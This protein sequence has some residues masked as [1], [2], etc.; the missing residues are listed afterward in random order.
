MDKPH[1]STG[2]AP[3]FGERFAAPRTGLL[4]V[5]AVVLLGW[6]LQALGSIAVP[7]VF[8]FFLTLL[9]APVDRWVSERVPGKVKWLGHVA[10]M[11]TVVLGVAVFAACLWLAAQQLV[12][13]FAGEPGGLGSLLPEVSI[14][15]G[16]AG[17]ETGTGGE[18]GGAGPAG[19]ASLAGIGDGG[20]AE[21]D[22][23]GASLLGG[24]ALETD[25]A[26][27][28]AM[29]DG[30]TET[31]AAAE[32]QGSG[33][34]QVVGMARDAAG[35]LASALS[36]WAAN[37]AG[38]I[39]AAAGSFVSA[40]VLVFFL[41]LLMLV[42]A[43]RWQGKLATLL[44]KGA[45]ED[46][47]DATAV[48][49]DR[50]RRFLLI[51]L[52]IGLITAALYVGWLWVFGI[53]LLLVWGLLAVLLNFIPTIGSLIAGLLPVIYAFA[54]KDFGTAVMVGAGILV[55]EQI[56][57]NFVDPRIQG[58]TVSLS[59]LVILVALLLWGWLWGIAGA[60]LAVPITIT[61]LVVGAHVPALRPFAL[62]VSNEIDMEGLER[63]ASR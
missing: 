47:F 34:G 53:D 4:V 23:P 61:F 8:A 43:P 29:E 59:S 57:G 62:L 16:T 46:A 36:D 24:G 37:L 38:A 7:L 45:R 49:A 3:R 17:G 1:H 30:A 39:V 6:A 40:L 52:V 12:T 21:K 55:I 18:A 32:G 20:G 10:A 42:E 11:V 51:R 25:A 60:F 58:R 33:L 27:D 50:L 28:G 15:A 41:T 63:S 22:G 35:S 26:V 5:I 2:S 31:G 56:M 9:V 44:D 14:P 13:R 54:L 19:G 48:I